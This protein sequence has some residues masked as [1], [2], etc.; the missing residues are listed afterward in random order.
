MTAND[1]KVAQELKQR[2]AAQA[3][4]V[5]FRVFGSR[6]RGDADEASDM[7]VFVEVES[8]TPE[9]RERIH[10]LAWEVGFKHFMVISPLV[11]SRFEIEKTPLR[12]SPIIRNITR[13]GVA[14]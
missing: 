7:D 6:A 2:L 10:E 5:D 13:E 1:L 11:V 12:S 14:V 8:L 3:S 4:L 9:V